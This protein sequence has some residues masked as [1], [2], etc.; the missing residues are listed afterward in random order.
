MVSFL[1]SLKQLTTKDA[2]APTF[3]KW[4]CD[5]DDNGQTSGQY[6][7]EKFLDLIWYKVSFLIPFRAFQF[8][9]FLYHCSDVDFYSLS[10]SFSLSKNSCTILSALAAFPYNSLTANKKPLIFFSPLSWNWIINETVSFLLV[11]VILV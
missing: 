7:S 9:F 4:S 5:N 3:S 2:P 6:I 8:N 10:L 11:Y 1:A